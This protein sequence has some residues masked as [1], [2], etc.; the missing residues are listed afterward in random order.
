MLIVSAVP[1]TN[2]ESEIH[3]IGCDAVDYSAIMF[4]E[5]HNSLFEGCSQVPTYSI[6]LKIAEDMVVPSFLCSIHFRALKMSLED[7]IVGVD[8]KILGKQNEE[9]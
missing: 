8:E 9:D 1:I 5:K 7:G 4:A 3:E 6:A 2:M